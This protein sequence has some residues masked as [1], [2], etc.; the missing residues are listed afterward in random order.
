MNR[1]STPCLFL[2]PL[3]TYAQPVLEYANVQLVGSTYA[4]HLVT[5]AGTSDPNPNG[6]NVTW[7]FSSATLLMNAG[8][9][10]FTAPAGTPYA[11]SYPTS[12]LAQ[13]IDLPT[14]TTYNYF[15]LG[16]TQLDMLGEGIG[17]TNATIYTDPKTPLQFPFAYPD[18]FIDY[19]TYG[20]T[21]YS[22]SRAYMGYGTVILP[23]GTYTNV[24]KM[25]STSGSIDF[26]RSNPVSQ[27]VNIGSDGTVI[28][29][30]DPQTGLPAT[31]PLPVLNAFPNPATDR[32]LISGLAGSGTWELRDLQGRVIQSGNHGAGSMELD[33]A[34]AST[35]QY[36]LLLND[37]HGRRHAMINKH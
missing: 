9:T 22:V 4:V 1:L 23:T 13:R 36:A 32:V 27:L 19:F 17:G 24:V 20:G 6:A 31:D 7:D 16:S 21:N 33:L 37:A 5:N 10:T 12:N 2:L 28:V 8:T 34:M 29:F 18:Y 14:G 11:A 15:N 26:F 30:G 35:G 3:I 25:A